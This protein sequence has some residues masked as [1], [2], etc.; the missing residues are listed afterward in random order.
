MP[1]S[2][3][4]VQLI[5]WVCNVQYAMWIWLCVCVWVCLFFNLFS[6]FLFSFMFLSFSCSMWFTVVQTA[7][8]ICLLLRWVFCIV[9]C[10]CYYLFLFFFL[11]SV[12]VRTNNVNCILWWFLY[13]SLFTR[14]LPHLLQTVKRTRW[15]TSSR[16]KS[17]W[18]TGGNSW[19]YWEY[20]QYTTVECFENDHTS[21]RS[22]TLLC[23]TK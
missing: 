4:S 9:W 13:V 18:N 15:I 21:M 14:I 22:I 23:H 10:Y 6:V 17:L 11:F 20:G 16:G 3:H 19:V 8:G 2:L 12:V 7:F 5:G 1:R